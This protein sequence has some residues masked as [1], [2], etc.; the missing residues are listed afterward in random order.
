[1][2]WQ[3]QRAIHLSRPKGPYVNGRSPQ[4]L[5][6]LPEKPD[7]DALLETECRE[8]VGAMAVCVCGPGGLGDDVRAA[9]RRR[10][11]GRSVDFF[12]EGFGW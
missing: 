6:M 8:Q 3:A 12:E 10:Q 1:M 4:M 7:V 9:V 5:P 11:G 2:S